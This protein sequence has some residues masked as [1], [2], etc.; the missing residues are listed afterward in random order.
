MA[1]IILSGARVALGPDRARRLDVT[2][3]GGCI[4]A[5]GSALGGMDLSGHL[6]LPGLINAHDHLEF[7]LFPRLG[8]GP[9]PNATA[10][11][12]DIHRPEESPVREHRR[13]PKRVRLYWGG[14]KNLVGGV[15]TVCHHNTYEPGMFGAHFPVRVVRNFGWA[16]SL[17]FSPDLLR[18]YRRSPAGR[19]F[20]FHAGEATDASGHAEIA[21][22][23]SMGVIE[24][25]VLVHGISL[26]GAGLRLLKKRGASLITCP[27]SNIFTLGRTLPREAFSNGLAIALGT[28]S[29]ISARGDFLD[30]LRFTHRHCGLVP[31]KLYVMA[32]ATAAKILCLQNGEGSIEENAR[33]DLIAIRDTGL[34]PAAALLDARRIEL[35]IVGGKIRLISE[36]LAARIGAPANFEPLH[37]AGRGR[38]L[39]DAPVAELHREAVSILKMPLR[40]AGKA[41]SV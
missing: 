29:G 17:A 6:I 14:L 20:I 9:Y 36:R 5:L 34:A 12:R 33:A 7:N 35:A 41:V 21:E 15:T 10:W 27:V 16:H 2:I 19:P 31:K 11:A 39:V 13:I 26:H 24:G 3:R 40:V 37:I 25:S 30:A 38:V 23:D 18:R 22:L 8:R 4:A 1:E 28:D 32:T